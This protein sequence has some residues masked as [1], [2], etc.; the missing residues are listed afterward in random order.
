M[1]SAY[2]K[3]RSYA[4]CALGGARLNDHDVEIVGRS[5]RR[6]KRSRSSSMR[7]LR[8]ITSVGPR[9]ETVAHFTELAP[10]IRPSTEQPQRR[11]QHDTPHGRNRR[12]GVA[13]AIRHMDETAATSS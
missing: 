5:P 2:G 7:L 3:I 8:N 4:A 11:G 10:A 1:A 9:G 13:S 12:S 6:N